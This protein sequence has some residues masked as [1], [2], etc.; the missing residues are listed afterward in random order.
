MLSTIRDLISHYFI[1]SVNSDIVNSLHIFNEKS[2]ILL[3]MEAATHIFKSILTD[4]AALTVE[5][6]SVID[7]IKTVKNELPRIAGAG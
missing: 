2:N 5:V 3:L 1:N 6:D 4:L 7:G